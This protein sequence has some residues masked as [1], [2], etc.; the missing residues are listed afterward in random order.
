M[1]DVEFTSATKFKSE[2]LRRHAAEGV[3][4]SEVVLVE[5]DLPRPTVRKMARPTGGGEVT[6]SKNLVL[7]SPDEDVSET[8]R[9]VADARKFLTVLTGSEPRFL[10][11]SQVFIVEANG[12]QLG[13]IA[14]H[15]LVAA[16]WPNR[17]V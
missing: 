6:R 11:S 7:D 17:N 13:E 2:D 5:I 4:D 9:K 12:R 15:P 14:K 8:N 1:P 10:A 16:I 3:S